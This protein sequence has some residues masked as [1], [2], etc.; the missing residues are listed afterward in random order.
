MNHLIRADKA[1]AGVV[2]DGH[3]VDLRAGQQRHHSGRAC[4]A[5]LVGHVTRFGHARG[6][7]NRVTQHVHVFGRFGLEGQEVHLTPALVGRGQPGVDRNVASPH[8]RND[9]EHTGLEVVVELE[10]QG[11]GGDIHVRDIVFVAV[12]DDAFVAIGPGLLEQRAFGCHIF[13][14]V[15]NQHLALGLGFA[16]VLGHLAGALVRAGRAAVRR[17]RD[18]HGEHTAVGHGH[19]LLAQRQGLRAGLPG[20]HHLVFGAGFV[21]AGQGFPHVVNAGRHDQAVVGQLGAASE[22]NEALVG[23]NAVHTVLDHLHAVALGQVVIRRG[24]VGHGFAAAN[25]QIG[26][27]ARHEVVV[28]LDQRDLDFLIRPHAYVLGSSGTGKTAANDHHFGAATTAY[29]GAR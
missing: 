26:N 13:V 21:H 17:Q 19:Q 12:L 28:G 3:V 11:L 2:V 5:M 4:F 18:G 9:V 8:G 16:E 22:L 10:L 29:G 23:I 14:G 25:H 24:D 6:D 27:G 1:V 15:Q 7:L 20:V